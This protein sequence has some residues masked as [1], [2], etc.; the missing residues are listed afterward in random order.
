MLPSR[1]SN[2]E[3][4]MSFTDAV[5]IERRVA[6]SDRAPP[7]R[8]NLD[9]TATVRRQPQI[10]IGVFVDSGRA[11]QLLMAGGSRSLNE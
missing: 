11:A 10:A 3:L 1:S 7:A 8:I 4:S 5:G 9:Q 2:T 6:V